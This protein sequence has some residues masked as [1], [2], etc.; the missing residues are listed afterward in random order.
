[1][2]DRVV[3]PVEDLRAAAV[4]LTARDRGR[5][6]LPAGDD[7]MEALGR[8]F[9][10]MAESLER[11]AVLIA[12]NTARIEGFNARLQATVEERTAELRAAQARLVEAARLAA[13]GELGAGVAH[14]LN[15]PL[16]GILGLAQVLERRV[17]DPEAAGLLSSLSA[18]ARRCVALVA[19]LRAV[20]GAG[21]GGAG[22]AVVEWAP[23]LHEVAALVA[24]PLRARGVT[25]AV[26]AAGAGA[27]WAPPAVLRPALV[28]LL[29]ARG[30]A[31]PAGGR[32]CLTA[33]PGGGLRLALDGPTIADTD[34][35]RAA[36]VPLWAARR[37][38]A[39]LGASLDAPPAPAD[40]LLHLPV[41]EG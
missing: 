22:P 27:V 31:L 6:V 18:E 37:A 10:T 40:W 3:R 25:L 2:A 29:L 20:A 39:D 1:M 15:N 41:P 32:I 7:E 30:A 11:D 36:S 35:A 9:N 17:G 23:M 16:A 13:V 26:S 4:A 19:H 38:L 21:E 28:Q 24:G 8:V 12:E 14:E 5:R 34:D 33:A